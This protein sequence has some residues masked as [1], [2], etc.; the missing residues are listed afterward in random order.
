MKLQSLRKENVLVFHFNV[1]IVEVAIFQGAEEDYGYTVIFEG[2]FYPTF[3]HKKEFYYIVFFFDKDILFEL[4]FHVK[5][6]YT[7]C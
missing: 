4:R 7:R 1:G 5:Y 6:L 3:G 2:S